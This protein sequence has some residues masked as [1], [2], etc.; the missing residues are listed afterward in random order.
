[1]ACGQVGTVQQYGC[2][3]PGVYN[4]DVVIPMRK[5]L[6]RYERSS[7]ELNAACD[8]QYPLP[9]MRLLTGVIVRSTCRPFGSVINDEGPG[10]HGHS[11]AWT[12]CVKDGSIPPHR[13]YDLY[14]GRAVVSGFV[15]SVSKANNTGS[16]TSFALSGK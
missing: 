4:V 16:M 8:S 14:T 6:S 9:P 10:I 1:M 13:E 3:F 12:R 2:M 11:G 7:V 5:E 15:Y